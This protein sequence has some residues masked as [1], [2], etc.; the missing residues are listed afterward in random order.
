[1]ESNEKKPIKINLF[2]KDLLIAPAGTTV[3]SLFLNKNTHIIWGGSGKGKSYSPFFIKHNLM[4]KNG[5]ELKI[6]LQEIIAD[7]NMQ[8]VE[9]DQAKRILQNIESV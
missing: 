9:I 6:R 7:K 4:G 1:M 8:E 3:M 5:E 2:E